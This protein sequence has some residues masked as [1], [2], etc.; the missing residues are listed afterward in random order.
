M[1]FILRMIM[2]VAK[3]ITFDRFYTVGFNRIR[4]L[5]PT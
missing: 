4:H 5:D 2:T 1:M 3:M